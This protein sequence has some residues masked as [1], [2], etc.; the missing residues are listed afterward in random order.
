MKISYWL[1]LV[2]LSVSAFSQPAWGWKETGHQEV[3]ALAWSLLDQP[4]RSRVEALLAGQSIV[5][6]AQGLAGEAAWIAAATWPDE[7]RQKKGVAAVPPPATQQ[8][9]LSRSRSGEGT[10]TWHYVNLDV[11][12]P[13]YEQKPAGLLIQALPL[14]IKFL[15]DKS[16]PLQE[17]A[18]ALVWVSHLVGD[19]HQ[20]MHCAT[21]AVPGNPEK[22]DGGGNLIMVVEAGQNPPQPVTL[23]RWWDQQ[24]GKAKPGSQQ[25]SQDIARLRQASMNTPSV[26]LA[27]PP[28]SWIEESFNIGRDVA[29]PGLMADPKEPSMFL[30]SPSY[31]QTSY[32]IA[33][34]R[35]ALAGRRLAEVVT[36][37]LAD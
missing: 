19:A 1:S 4:T 9:W 36:K 29:Y 26:D 6:N 27:N 35:V 20:P 22:L 12:K 31:Q 34:A 24:P 8:Q 33:Q 17:R 13:F 28:I 30:I 32:D 16:L 15:S 11:A 18:M 10:P 5:V 2:A 3:V 7:I 37:A 23:H 21:R 14:Q 25:F